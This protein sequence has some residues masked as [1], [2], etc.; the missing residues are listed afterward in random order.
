MKVNIKL[1]K[2]KM[3]EQLQGCLKKICTVSKKSNYS[4]LTDCNN[5]EVL[6]I[7]GNN[8][9]YTS[10]S[11]EKQCF[12]ISECK[13]IR[14]FTTINT[15]YRKL[16]SDGNDDV[17]VVWLLIGENGNEKKLVQVGRN[18]RLANALRGDI[19]VDARCIMEGSGAEKYVKLGEK[20]EKLI[21]Y[22]VNI[23]EY[24]KMCN[25]RNIYLIMNEHSPQNKYLKRAYY[26][27]KAAYVEGKIASLCDTEAGIW[28]SSGDID[29]DI[30]QYYNKCNS[31]ESHL[32]K[33]E[34]NIGGKKL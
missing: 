15:V 16:Y 29:D 13:K 2:Q 14:Y 9:Y 6:V 4:V 8:I 26:N 3:I 33:G 20:F 22:Q 12:N 27:F 32:F 21:F 31:S 18:N 25:D 10:L 28:N 11:K 34:I 30:Y 5:R 17:A 23:D 24:L 1:D 19:N 7:E